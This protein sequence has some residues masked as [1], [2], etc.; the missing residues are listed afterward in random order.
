MIG[1]PAKPNDPKI[2]RV[3]GGRKDKV[4]G[5]PSYTRHQG[6]PRELS[7][8]SKMLETGGERMLLPARRM[9]IR[10][11]WP[12]LQDVELFGT[13]GT[14]DLS[15]EPYSLLPGSCSS[16]RWSTAPSCGVRRMAAWGKDLLD[17]WASSG[18]AAMRLEGLGVAAVP[19]SQ[20][21]PQELAIPQVRI[22]CRVAGVSQ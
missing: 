4:K 7:A 14:H 11:V 9:A 19:S 3:L 13:Q 21:G 6:E 20:G 8:L 5:K 22:Q 2:G 12:T 1:T 10:R 15:P 18:I 16:C 17:P